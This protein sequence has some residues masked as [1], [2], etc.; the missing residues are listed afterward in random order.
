MF[1]FSSGSPRPFKLALITPVPFYRGGQKY[2][3]S[4][5]TGLSFSHNRAIINFDRVW[6]LD[7][8]NASLLTA[9]NALLI[10]LGPRWLVSTPYASTSVEAAVPLRVLTA[11]NWGPNLFAALG[12]QLPRRPAVS[13]L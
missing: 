13:E 4:I 1:T 8:L 10:C 7:A 2:A 11:L 3:S 9:G 6:W 5:Y 12:N